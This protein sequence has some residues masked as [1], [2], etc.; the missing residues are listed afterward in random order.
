MGVYLSS[1]NKTK[2]TES[3]KNSIIEYGLSSMQG[4]R[5][6]MENSH[7]ALPFYTP[8][9][10]LF[11][12]FDGHGG[13]EISKFCLENFPKNLK[14]NK[15]FLSKNYEKSLIETCEKMDKLLKTEKGQKSLK[16]HQ[17]EEDALNKHAGCTA[18]ILLITKQKYYT[19]NIGDS[20]A[21][22]FTLEEEIENLSF[23]HNPINKN[24]KK[25]IEKAG[26]YVLYGRV[27][28]NI[29]LSRSI[30]DLSYKENEKFQDF[31]QIVVSTPDLEIRD[32]RRIEDFVVLGCAGF[33]ETFTENEVCEFV[34]KFVAEGMELGE[35]VEKLLDK[36]IA[37]DTVDGVGCDNMTC[38]VIK[39]L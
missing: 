22:L 15:N 2:K 4:W 39:F 5:M 21:I 13:C 30:G 26:G 17:K 14:K 25:R 18:L 29:K 19:A 8:T 37:K 10:S 12:I 34:K 27:N 11:A 24:E 38:I 36:L 23:A 1:P 28:G 32:F 20:K 35:V 33:W 31:E 7:I 16:K 6:S 9:T 3:G